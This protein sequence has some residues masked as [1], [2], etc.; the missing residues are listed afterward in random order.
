MATFRAFAVVPAAG[1]SQRM[2]KPKLLLPWKHG[3]IIEATLAAW[4]ASSVAAIVV[5]VRPDDREL[6]EI[7]ARAGVNVLTPTAAPPHMRDSVQAALQQIASNY[8]PAEGDVWLLA[9]ADMPHLSSAIV[10][11]LV[12]AHRPDAPAILTPTLDQRAGHPVLFP[13]PLASQVPRLPADRGINA[14]RWENPTRTV[15]CDH[16]GIA[17]EAF[18]DL[19]TPEQYR[20]ARQD[21]TR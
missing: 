9:P 7:C 20:Q 2:G 1:H 12:A 16:L 18:G 17:R 19:D 21:G 13:W 15:S 10:D 11:E 14:L 3:T 8:H 4:K 6:A 5:V